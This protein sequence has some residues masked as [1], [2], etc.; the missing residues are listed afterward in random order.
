LARHSHSLVLLGL[1]SSAGASRFGA[2]PT[3]LFPRLRALSLYMSSGTTYVASR[4]P[5][6]R[7]VLLRER[8]G[9]SAS[10]LPLLLYETLEVG[11]ARDEVSDLLHMVTVRP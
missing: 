7:R 6:L 9:M 4:Y 10:F 1:T 3:G 5:V 11:K 8:T 2:G